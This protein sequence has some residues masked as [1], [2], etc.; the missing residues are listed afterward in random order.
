MVLTVSFVLAPVIGLFVTVI[1]AMR[2]HPRQLDSGVE[3]S[4]PHDFIVRVPLR[5]SVDAA[6]VHRIPH[7]TFVTIA[8]R[9]LLWGTGRA[10]KCF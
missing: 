5:S 4:G 2:E 8:K 3:E 1:V 10:E 7:P 9:P 6:H